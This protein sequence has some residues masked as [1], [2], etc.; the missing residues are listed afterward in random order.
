MAAITGKSK[1]TYTGIKS[2]KYGI[3]LKYTKAYCAGIIR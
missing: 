3:R 1:N 2:V